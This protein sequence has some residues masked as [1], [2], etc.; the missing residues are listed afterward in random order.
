VSGSP[1]DFG[2]VVLSLW[3]DVVWLLGGLCAALAGI[4]CLA[5]A[6]RIARGGRGGI[7]G[8]GH[9]RRAV[10]DAD[11]E[12]LPVTKAMDLGGLVIGREGERLLQARAAAL[13]PDALT[14]PIGPAD[15][16]EWCA[17]GPADDAQSPDEQVWWGKECTCKSD[18]GHQWCPE[19]PDDALAGEP[20]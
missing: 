20:W 6:L 4:W 7:P 14:E 9:L 13:T 2:D 15:D 12:H 11:R 3:P 5:A 18:C 10:G 8:H 1:R 19:Q 17:D 16:C